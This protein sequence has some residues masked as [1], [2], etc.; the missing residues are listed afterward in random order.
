MS[1]YGLNQTTLLDY[2]GHLAATLFLGGCNFLC[3]Y[4]HNR[5][6]VLKDVATTPL[7]EENV[8]TFLEKRRTVLEGVCI[9]GGEPTLYPKLFDLLKK[10]KTLG[11]KIKLDTNGT[12]PGRLQQLLDAGLLDYVAMDI[13]NSPNNYAMTIGKTVFSLDA[14]IESVRRLKTCSIDYEFRTTVVKE[15]HKK[16]DFIAIGQWLSGANAYYLQNFEPSDY[17]I[18]SGFSSH[19]IDTLLE[20]KEVLTPYIPTVALRGV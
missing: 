17:Q 7:S 14:I 5:S 11:Y 12:S 19:S 20:F 16:E 15:F 3:P 10:I 13:K 2:P 4:C 8:L 18:V 1:I 9:T 6:L